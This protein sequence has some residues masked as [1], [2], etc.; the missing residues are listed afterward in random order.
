MDEK[1]WE[2]LRANTEIAVHA[3]GDQG[4][5]LRGGPMD[6][7]L[8]NEDAPSLA[9]DWYETWPPTVAAKNDPGRYELSESGTWAEWKPVEEEN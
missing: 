8:V 2:E 4:V 7:W 9:P 3:A 1:F 6:G 5:R